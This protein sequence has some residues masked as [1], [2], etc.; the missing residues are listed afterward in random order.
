MR[1]HTIRFWDFRAF[2]KKNPDVTWKLL[3]HVAGL[4]VKEQ[5][6]HTPRAETTPG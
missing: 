3:Q 4:V 2:A 1:C 5:S 6:R